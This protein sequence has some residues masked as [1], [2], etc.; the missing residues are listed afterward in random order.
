MPFQIQSCSLHKMGPL[1][2]RFKPLARVLSHAWRACLNAAAQQSQNCQPHNKPASICCQATSTSDGAAMWSEWSSQTMSNR[3]DCITY[4]KASQPF[5]A[6]G[7]A[8]L[9]RMSVFA[10]CPCLRVSMCAIF[11]RFHATL[12]TA[13]N[14]SGC[15][16]A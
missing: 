1:S 9:L 13:L 10:M 3:I 7:R 6:N 5:I 15:E 2:R 4:L 16:F 11:L 8:Q 12:P 14:F